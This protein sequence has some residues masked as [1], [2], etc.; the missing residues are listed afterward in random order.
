MGKKMKNAP[1]YYALAQVR[2]NP[3]AAMETYVPAIQEKL[4]K[5]YPDFQPQQ[6]ATLVFSGQQIAKPSVVTRYLFLNTRKTSGFMLEQGAISF[7]T[8]DYDTFDPFLAT[9]LEGLEIL[10]TEAVLSY[11]ERVGVRFLDAVCPSAGET[12]SQYLQPYILGLSDRLS[13]REL[14]HSLSETRTR[15]DKSVLVGRTVILRQE[16]AGA[17]FPDDLRPVPI[18]LIDKFSKVKGEYAVI[19]TDSWMED[20]Q[21]FDLKALDSTCRVL[22]DSMWRSFEL[23]VTPHALKIWD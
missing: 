23:M 17:A 7:Q 5:G 3:L 15:L 6:V 14:V 22:H 19:D 4:R 12:I 20:R 8:T 11:S 2:F 13:G 10:H 1:V 16:N 18:N 21:D 9:L